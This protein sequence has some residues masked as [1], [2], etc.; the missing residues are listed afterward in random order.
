MAAAP[1]AQ[2]PAGLLPALEEA[3]EEPVGP[4]CVECMIIA[5]PRPG[6][7]HNRAAFG[8]TLQLLSAGFDSVGLGSGF[9]AA[10]RQGATLGLFIPDFY[11]LHREPSE[12]HQAY[13]K[14]HKAWYPMDMVALVGEAISSN[15][16][17][18]TG[19]RLRAYATAG[20]PVY[21]LVD[22]HAG[23]GYAYCDPVAH[24]DEPA[25]S[26][27]RA[28]STSTPDGKLTLPAPYPVLDV[29]PLLGAQPVA[30]L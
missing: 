19:P 1:L 30:G 27:Y 14:A 29:A 9:R 10:S 20:V 22:R 8:P 26:Q 3:S 6:H 23:A 11:V 12:L 24:L 16:E 13:L 7:R 25:R 21:V 15:H 18:D 28:R 2:K 5:P 17:T 4:E